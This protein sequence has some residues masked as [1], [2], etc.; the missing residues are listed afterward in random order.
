MLLESY[1]LFPF[2]LTL[3]ILP[4]DYY[5]LFQLK[6][7]KNS[8]KFCEISDFEDF[9]IEYFNTKISNLF[10][11]FPNALLGALRL[12]LCP[13]G[14]WSNIIDLMKS[15]KTMQFEILWDSL[16]LKPK[17]IRITLNLNQNLITR[18]LTIML[19]QEADHVSMSSNIKNLSEN[20][21]KLPPI[22]RISYILTKDLQS[23]NFS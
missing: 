16:F 21:S 2:S 7:Q 23:F 1:N 18:P 12:F 15:E 10:F 8:E 17:T 11:S 13:V 20:T 22:E 14:L 19:Y 9:I 6:V 5:F 3:S 4:K